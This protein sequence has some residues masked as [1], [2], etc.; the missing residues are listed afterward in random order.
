MQVVAELHRQSARNAHV[1]CVTG[2]H[3]VQVVAEQL[4]RVTGE[5]DEWQAEARQLAPQLQQAGALL[6]A[7]EAE[8]EDLRQ[9]Y[10][11]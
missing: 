9:A 11:V 8:V 6:G 4:A 5:R 7:R 3:G 10:E 2:L 1:R